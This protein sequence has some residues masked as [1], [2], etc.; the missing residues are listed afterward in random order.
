MSISKKHFYSL[1]RNHLKYRLLGFRSMFSDIY[2]I[3]LTKE[4]Q[5]LFLKIRKNV[6]IILENYYENHKLKMKEFDD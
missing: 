1:K 6:D 3:L 4:E 2:F 5:K